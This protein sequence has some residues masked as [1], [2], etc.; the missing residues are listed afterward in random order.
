M[1]IAFKEI[2]S[3]YEECEYE[4]EKNRD[5]SF[6]LERQLEDAFSKLSSIQKT[7]MTSDLNINSAVESNN[8]SISNFKSEK[9]SNITDKQVYSKLYINI[10]KSLL[11]D[12]DL[13]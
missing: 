4:L 5:K 2:N 9:G 3:K 12:Y 7:K 13:K 6:K 10:Y 8:I 1:D 11:Y